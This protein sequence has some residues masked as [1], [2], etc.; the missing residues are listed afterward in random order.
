MLW[1]FLGSGYGKREHEGARVIA[2]RK[3]QKELSID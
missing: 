1:K 3:L 2:K